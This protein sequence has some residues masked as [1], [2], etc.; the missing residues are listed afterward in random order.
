MLQQCLIPFFRHV[1]LTAEE[2]DMHDAV[3]DSL[4]G[5]AEDMTSS[6]P[7]P[8]LD[9]TGR[10]KGG[11]AFERCGQRP[12]KD[13]GRCYSLTMTHQRSRALVGPTGP[14]KFY[15]DLED[16]DEYSINLEMRK[17]VTKVCP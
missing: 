2:M 6:K 9:N 7:V 10:L 17:K 3:R 1:F 8:D 16:T 12:V 15:E 11:T 14:G 4:L 13:S 5:P